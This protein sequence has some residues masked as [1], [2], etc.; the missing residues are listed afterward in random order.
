MYH[1]GKR[2]LLDASRTPLDRE[3]RLKIN[4]YKRLKTAF[5]IHLGSNRLPNCFKYKNIIHEAIEISKYSKK[6]PQKTRDELAKDFQISKNKVFVL[7]AL[8]RNLPPE[9]I[10]NFKDCEDKKLLRSFG[11]EKLLKIAKLASATKRRKAIN[12]LLEK[13]NMI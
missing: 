8:I 2:A 3:V 4:Y 9:F 5:Q 10:R 6:N 11:R 1:Q 12:Y 13:H 7:R